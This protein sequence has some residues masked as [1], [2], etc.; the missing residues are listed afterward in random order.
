MEAAKPRIGILRGEWLNPFELQSYTG[1]TRRYEL[2]GIGSKAGRFDV[3]SLPMPVVRLPP[4]ARGLNGSATE[5]CAI[6]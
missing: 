5:R 3:N 2:V 4:I 6:T 1:L